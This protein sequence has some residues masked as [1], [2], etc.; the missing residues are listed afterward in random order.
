LIV[1]CFQSWKVP[2][3]AEDRN[4]D[5]HPLRQEGTAIARSKVPP[6][7]SLI[8]LCFSGLLPMHCDSWC[9]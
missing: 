3:R 4:D 7:P 6:D 2:L 5:F 8:N 1:F 9:A